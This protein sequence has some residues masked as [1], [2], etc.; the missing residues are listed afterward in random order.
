MKKGLI[1]LIVFTFSASFLLAQE[2]EDKEVQVWMIRTIDGSEFIGKLLSEQDSLLKIDNEILGIIELPTSQVIW[3]RKMKGK[4]LDFFDRR[5]RK[6][7]VHTHYFFAP[8]AYSLKKGGGYVQNTNIIHTQINFAPTNRLSLG[9]NIIPMLLW[10]DLTP[11][12]LN[13]KYTFPLKEDRLN[14]A[15]GIYTGSIFDIGDNYNYLEEHFP[16]AMPY[17]ALTFGSRERNWTIAMGYGRYNTTLDLDFEVTPFFSLSGVYKI[18]KISYFLT[19][20]H[21]GSRWGST[22]LVSSLGFR[23]VAKKF[24]A[25]IGAVVFSFSDGEIRP[26]PLLSLNFPF[27]ASAR[28]E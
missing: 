27:G 14:F 7:A 19:E 3:K 21:I 1:L 12:W 4:D 11:I 28:L 2:R 16:F 25:D 15:L 17:G 20:N 22:Q 13:A 24:S 8:T 6:D 23:W 26:L 10:D 9:I 18:G 5:P